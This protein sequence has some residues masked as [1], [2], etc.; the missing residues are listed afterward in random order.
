MLTV[1]SAATGIPTDVN[2]TV[3]KYPSVSSPRDLDTGNRSYTP[4]R[5]LSDAMSALLY[6]FD[7]TI[8]L[9][10][11]IKVS[12]EA[13]NEKRRERRGAHGDV[14]VVMRGAQ[15]EAEV[16]ESRGGRQNASLDDGPD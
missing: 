10:P 3:L 1:S 13:L 5:E 6:N 12:R 16:E 14:D 9:R 7:N 2:C 11:E 4:A 15:K 8:A